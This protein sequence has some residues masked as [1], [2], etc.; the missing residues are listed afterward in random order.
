METK[1][2]LY[3]GK[4]NLALTL[5]APS[6]GLFAFAYIMRDFDTIIPV[7]AMFFGIV[8]WVLGLYIA[9]YYHFR[10]KHFQQALAAPLL[11]CQLTDSEVQAMANANQKTPRGKAIHYLMIS[12]EGIFYLGRF[13][14]LKD[15]HVDAI[16]WQFGSHRE[17]EHGTLKITYQHRT[18]INQTMHGVDTTIYIE[19]KD[20][21]ELVLLIPHAHKSLAAQV[22]EHLRN[23]HMKRR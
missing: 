14:R 10:E 21:G 13:L 18:N 8:G 5:L 9:L 15:V 17:K 1:P 7:Y 3:T 2:T 12:E 16:T 23:H 22:A 11:V 20:R 4:R 19:N 6:T